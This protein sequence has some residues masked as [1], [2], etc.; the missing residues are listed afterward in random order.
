MLGH[1][2]ATPEEWFSSEPAGRLEQIM[3]HKYPFSENTGPPLIAGSNLAFVMKQGK[4]N[5]TE[6]LPP[7]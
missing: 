3:P 5:I 2:A 4:G 7:L 6:S 1:K